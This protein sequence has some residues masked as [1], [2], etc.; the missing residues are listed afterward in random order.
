MFGHANER[1]VL[2]GR[3]YLDFLSKQDLSGLMKLFDNFAQNFRR[4][5]NTSFS[6]V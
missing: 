4:I 3:T 6:H 1:T 5:T 2:I